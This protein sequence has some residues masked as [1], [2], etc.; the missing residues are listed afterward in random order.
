M[1]LL[2]LPGLDFSITDRNAWGVGACP[3]FALACICMLRSTSG[4]KNHRKAVTT[5]TRTWS[6]IPSSYTFILVPSHQLACP[7]QDMN[8][9]VSLN[10]FVLIFMTYDGVQITKCLVQAAFW[11]C[12]GASLVNATRTWHGTPKALVA[13]CSFSLLLALSIFGIT[14]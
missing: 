4:N 3:C 8:C 11:K 6:Q 5:L 14:F 10:F 7:V 9:P 2:S 12:C 1:T 13:L